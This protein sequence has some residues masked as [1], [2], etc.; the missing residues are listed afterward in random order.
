MKRLVYKT[1]NGDVQITQPARC[2]EGVH[3]TVW[4]DRV[5]RKNCPEGGELV[6]VV[7]AADIPSDRTQREAWVWNGRKIVVDPSRVKPHRAK[8]AVEQRTDVPADLKA[9]ISELRQDV[10][11]HMQDSYEAMQRWVIRSET[12]KNYAM[13]ALRSDEEA[14]QGLLRDYRDECRASLA[15]MGAPEGKS[16]E[17]VAREI[18]ARVEANGKAVMP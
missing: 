7:D 18:L 13:N 8:R 10:A 6:G 2:P 11:A 5:A 9:L 17:V 12:E 16:F 4:L 3:E 14:P 1:Q 15:R